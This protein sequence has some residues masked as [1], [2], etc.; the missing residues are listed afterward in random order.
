M[1]KLSLDVVLSLKDQLGAGLQKIVGPAEDAAESVKKL[2]EQA[3]NL[4]RLKV[5]LDGFEKTQADT[6][7]AA[8]AL[9]GYKK[10]ITELKSQ[11]DSGNGD[12]GIAKRLKAAEKEAAKLQNTVDKGRAKMSSMASAL[13]KAGHGGQSFANAQKSIAN[14]IGKTNSALDKQKQK[15]E[16]IEKAQ[17]AI[18]KAGQ[19]R[20]HALNAL[21]VAG[22]VAG[23]AG[24]A[25]KAYADSQDAE[26]TLK[27]SMM[28]SDGKVAKEYKDIVRL[29]E[30]M[31]T[32][33][34]GTTADF[35]QMMAVLVQ[36]GISFQSILGGVG[37]SAGNLAVLLKMPFDQA[38]EFA[39]KL[40]DATKTTE[41]DMM[42]LM[43]TVQKMYYL[44]ADSTNILGGFKN[45]TSSMAVIGKHGKEFV[46]TV[47]PLLVMADQAGMNGD[48]AGNAYRKIFAGMMDTDG[49]NKA[50]KDAGTNLKFDFTNGKGEFGGFEK[51]FKQ[52]EQLKGVDTQ[53]RLEILSAAWGNDAEVA[54][55]LNIMI[56]KG[57]AGYDEVVAKMARQADINKRVQEQL[58]TLRN[59]WDAA[60]GTATS[61][62]ARAG[63]ALA[64]WVE[65]LTKWLTTLGEKMGEWIDRNPELFN[66]IVKVAAVIAGVVTVIAA[67]AVVVST[68]VIPLAALKMSFLTLGGSLGGIGKAFGIFG[69]IA[70]FLAPLKA[71]PFTFAGIKGAIMG[72]VGAVRAF[73]LA[74]LTN[75]ITWVVAGIA[76]A[77]FLIYKFW[78]P[79]KAF[80]AGIWDSIKA[81]A[82][83]IMP[84]FEAI[85]NAIKPALDWLGEF[86][87]LTQ[88]G[89]GNA[90]SLGQTVGGFLV[91]AFMALTAPMRL[92]WSVAKWL[93]DGLSG[94]FSGEISI[95]DIFA[96]IK[97]KF[98][99]FVNK[100]KEWKDKAVK[101]WDDFWSSFKSKDAPSAGAGG[102][103]DG[104]GFWSSLVGGFESA[105]TKI[106]ETAGGLW[107]SA[108][109]KFD[110][111]KGS[112]TTKAGEIW[113]SVTQAINGGGGVNI[114]ATI[115]AMMSGV[116]GTI[117]TAV[118][119]ISSVL[120]SLVSSIGAAMSAVPSIVGVAFGAIPA[121]VSM[122]FGGLVAIV[123]G[124]M[125]NIIS[126]IGSTMS[127][128]P[129]IVG[130]AFSALP[131]IVA[132]A[133]SSLPAIIA[134]ALSS[135]PAMMAGVFA[136]LGAAT[137]VGM[138]AVTRAVTTGMVQ[139]VNAVRTGFGRVRATISS[140]WRGMGSAMSG[141]P[142]LS[143]LQAAMNQAIGYL[144]GIKG[145][146]AAI[147]ADISAGLA[148]GIQSN[149]GQ[150]Q[151]A[152]AQLARAAESAAR[153]ASDTHSPSRKMMAVGGDMVA[154]LDAGLRQGFAPTLKNWTDNIG[155]LHRPIATP[156]IRATQPIM[157]GGGSGI[158]HSYTGGAINITINAPAGS[159]QRA[160]AREVA[161]ELKK[162]ERAQAAKRRASFSDYE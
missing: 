143:R 152:A 17:N 120:S 134:A 82:A 1:S 6:K 26:T 52:L 140:M 60:S 46:D 84:V 126:V 53:K 129:T 12:S 89:E 67:L 156:P 136:T 45:L 9:M 40:Q 88:V 116:I 101:L 151:A 48:S 29:A 112:L 123:A 111:A 65:S 28:G 114:T 58:G 124:S 96:G 92:V 13:D 79:I 55:A 145:R 42:S 148:R 99:E 155:T 10:L 150:V 146:F 76:A 27:I 128:V 2:Q 80:F 33:L 16:S 32:K 107:D 56:E 59:L 5:R 8:T 68:V 70:G 63:E 25:V 135:L 117:S 24:M 11:M 30:K 44:G 31:G 130:I 95:G 110:E 109:A 161:N 14:S 125:A 15:L 22:S 18:E 105:K 83:P 3:K 37:E 21:A 104:G 154:G 81:A 64:P 57:Q 77:A 142:I 41:K 43:D 86:F 66:G 113:S 137:L 35:K 54:Q 78:N 51:M 47:A 162:Y 141:N 20:E 103:G 73:S 93:W 69:K 133:V 138:M 19:V 90:R 158:S 139:V 62:M 71:I 74:L 36:Q 49:I 50:L 122:V 39:A 149:I 61:L 159:D 85:G 160:I 23:A 144:N 127:A 102:G 132:T 147:G 157:R 87:S 7:K 121:I 98:E 4:E 115:S 97:R 119:T 153:V 38:A 34:P 100:I 118:S 72:A 106:S 108:K 94:L 75:P 91:G 131:V